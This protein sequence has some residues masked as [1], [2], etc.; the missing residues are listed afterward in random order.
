M[1][2]A[3]KRAYILADNRLAENAGWDQE[4]LALEVLKYIAE[5]DLDFDLT[6]TGF[7]T[8]EIDLLD[9]PAEFSYRWARR[10]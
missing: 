6:V 8:A 4:L 2:E 7:E 3:Q 9:Q 5:S 1:T 10:R